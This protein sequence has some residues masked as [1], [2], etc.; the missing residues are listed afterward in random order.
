[1]RLWFRTVSVV[2]V[3]VH[4]FSSG[5]LCKQSCKQIWSKKISHP[6]ARESH[7]EASRMWNGLTVLWV[8]F[9]FSESAS[10]WVAEITQYFSV[11]LLAFTW[12]LQ[13][14]SSACWPLFTYPGWMT[15]LSSHPF[16]FI[17]LLWLYIHVWMCVRK[18]V[19]VSVHMLV[20]VCM[21]ACA[22]V[23]VGCIHIKQKRDYQLRERWQERSWIEE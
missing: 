20:S 11:W 12:W 6:T 19:F 10:L 14:D 23:C 21:K 4:E 8:G 9:F 22:C 7:L 16:L 17:L 2:H 3:Y 5:S 1:M 15:C 18:S 13:S